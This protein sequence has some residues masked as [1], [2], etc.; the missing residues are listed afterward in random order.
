MNKEDK[1]K[2]DSDFLR[3]LNEESPIQLNESISDYDFDDL[4]NSFNESGQKF[5]FSLSELPI[6]YMIEHYKY[7]K[8]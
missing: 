1:I 4:I 7:T 8:K 5:I 6:G 2:R 3:K